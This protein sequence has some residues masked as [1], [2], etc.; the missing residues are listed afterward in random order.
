MHEE[1]TAARKGVAAACAQGHAGPRGT[2][3]RK[4]HG[5]GDLLGDVV[6]VLIVPGGADI[7]EDAWGHVINFV[8]CVP[9]QPKTISVEIPLIVYLRIWHGTQRVACG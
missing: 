2:H 1:V 7:A 8:V 9:P 3:V 4:D 5:G 6:Q